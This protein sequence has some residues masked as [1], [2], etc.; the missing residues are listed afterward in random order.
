[1]NCGA[2]WRLIADSLMVRSCSAARLL[3]SIEMASVLTALIVGLAMP[4]VAGQQR[5]T[6]DNLQVLRKAAES[7][8]ADAQYRLG[9][10]YAEGEGVAKDPS[11]AAEWYRK[12]ATHGQPNAQ[13]NLGSLYYKGEGVPKDPAQAAEW[14]RKA[15]AQG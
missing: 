11:Q 6:N 15:A 3:N 5:S 9:L 4:C 14:Y 8:D 10:K 13:Y 12:A 7:G 2:V 1:M